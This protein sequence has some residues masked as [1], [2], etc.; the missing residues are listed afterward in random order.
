MPTSVP[1]RR[2][3]F[4]LTWAGMTS[5]MAPTGPAFATVAPTP[6]GATPSPRQL[7]WHKLETYGFLHFTV[8]TFT[9]REWGLGDEDPAIF[10]PTDYSAEQIVAACKA[11]G[12]KQLILT[13]KHHDGFCLWPSRFTEHSLKQSP[14]QNGQGDIVRDVSQACARHGVKFG[15]Y[16]SPWDRNHADYGRPAYVEYF[17]SQ[18]H[19]LL[20]SYGEIWEIWFDGA[21]GG[22]GYY[23]GA[24]ETRHIDAATYYQW[25]R[26]R[27][28]VRQLQP[29][30]ITWAEAGMDIRWVGNEGGVAGDPCWP[31]VD[32]TPY[33]PEKGNRGVRGGRIWNPAETNTSIRP[34]WFWHA[35]E[36][37]KVRSPA[38]LLTLYMTSVGRGTNLLLNVPPDRRGRVHEQDAKNLA[39]FRAILD[40]TFAKNLAHGARA[41]ASSVFSPS[42]APAN[43][44]SHKG[45][46]AAR[47][48]DRAGAWLQLDLPH[49][50]RFDL[51]RLSEVL[52]Y[53]VRIDDFE[54]EAWQNGQWRTLARH[55]CIGAQRL[56]RLETPIVADKVRL[57]VTKAAAAP[58]IADF[59]LFLL[60][61]VVEEPAIE[62]DRNGVVTLHASGP[63]QRLYYTLDGSTPGPHAT[64]YAQPFSLT[65]RGVVRAVAVKTST[66]AASA[67]ARADFDI[68]PGRWTATANG[69]AA[70]GLV[71]G[72]GYWAPADEAV[73]LVIDLTQSY[74]LKGFSLSA[75]T[76][77]DVNTAERCGP[78]AVY[79]AW[80]SEDGRSWGEP[81]GAGEFANIAASRSGQVIRFAAPHQ[82]R[83]LRLALPRAVQGKRAISIGRVGV[84]T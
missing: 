75:A 77:W 13:A 42:Y 15:V 8:N 28:M 78:P 19:E 80:V 25:D 52:T 70:Q 23:G 65:E 69:H 29:Q 83:Y 38:N 20:T 24:R 27:Q 33:S 11:G 63:D 26:V 10:N 41:S 53:G 71:D 16:L 35:D 51:I 57:R 66:G 50:A 55:S 4:G 1:S 17:L 61:D 32:E 44:L 79:T 74:A 46:W 67:P 43:V 48:D 56:I 37:D 49:P 60:P 39:A 58:I 30:A 36:N 62:R 84:L 34:G 59:S 22:D 14:F 21:N 31:T 12:L 47:A 76:A 5:A 9:D 72:G 81:A 2:T 6:W 54:V 18:L 40:E 45:Q 7:A 3:F 82:G 73:D 68:A 64:A